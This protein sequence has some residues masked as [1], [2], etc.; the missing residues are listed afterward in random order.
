ME[1]TMQ[2]KSEAS[3]KVL[4]TGGAVVIDRFR[5]V[6][7]EL[8]A[9]D[10]AAMSRDTGLHRSLLAKYNASE[11]TPRRPSLEAIA[12]AKKISVDWLLGKGGISV[13]FDRSEPME[14]KTS[15]PVT[16]EP[17]EVIPPL[18]SLGLTR[19]FREVQPFHNSP[20]KYWL[21][22]R[23]PNA[24]MKLGAQTYLLVEVCE[25]RGTLES[26]CGNLRIIKR[27]NSVALERV[28]RKNM[29]GEAKIVG[30]AVML[31]LDLK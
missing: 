23:E 26:D 2:K 29:H 31:E 16:E 11:V 30:E 8:Y 3:Q 5:T 14:L 1:I 20:S 18:S 25:A 27:S 10:I 6:L 19:R 17:W 28:A 4:K 22:I 9:G 15:R 13:E 12:R 7:R 24:E 21:F